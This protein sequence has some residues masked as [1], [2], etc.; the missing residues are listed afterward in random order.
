V[1]FDCAHDVPFDHAHDRPLVPVKLLRQH[2][3]I[4]LILTG[5]LVLGTVYSVVTPLFE[6]SDELWHYPFVKHLAEGGGLPVQDPRVEQ[7]WRQEGSQPPLYYAL[8]ALATFWI[9]T[10]DF[11]EVRWLNPH[12]DIGVETADGNLNMIVHSQREHFPYRG[13]AL[14]VHIV[15]FL[16][17]LMGAVT[18]LCTYLMALE[19]FPG[20]K[21]LAAGAAAFN[22][23]VPMFLFISGSV[24]NDNLTIL[25]C[26][27]TLLLLVRLLRG[28]TP[29]G[30][31]VNDPLRFGIWDLRLGH[32]SLLG[33]VIGLGALSKASAVGLLP[34]TALTLV[35]SAWQ[36]RAEPVL[37]RLARFLGSFATVLAVSLAVAGWWYLRNWLLYRDPLGLNTFVA[38][39]GPRLHQP[40]LRQLLGEWEGFVKAFW[41]LFGGVNVTMEPAVYWM[42]NVFAI[43]GL[44]GL[45]IALG[46]ALITR[47]TFHASKY[48]SSLATYHSSLTAHYSLLILLTWPIILFLAL[49][50]WTTITKASQGR[51]MFPAIS[52]IAILLALGWSQWVPHRFEKWLLGIVGGLMFASAAIAP[53]RYIVPAY[54]KPVLLSEAEL[55]AIPHR[56]DATF[57]SKAKLLGYKS[58]DEEI[59]PGESVEV[60]LY[61]Q[62]LAEMDRD[63][64]VF[65]H[66]LDENDLV[67]GQRDT[68]PGLGTY[69]TRLWRVGDAFAD[70]YVLTL[71]PTVFTPCTGRFEVG[72]YD[73]SS[74]ERLPVTGP[75]GQLLGDNIRF[76]QIAV[77]PRKD[78]PVPNP[79]DFDFEG[80]IALVG[81]DLDRR[82]ARSGETLRLTLYWQALTEMEEDYTV[83][84]HVLGEE[85]HLWAQMDSQPQG[86]TAPTSSWQ[87]G[88]VVEDHYDLVVKPDT[89]PD[90]YDIEVGLYQTATGQRLGVLDEGGRLRDN[91]VLLSKV[92]VK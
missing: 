72:L 33:L 67:I 13:T 45:M 23:F 19:I 65:V 25:L 84:T 35:L 14:A 79:V 18:V 74:E 56:L 90:V 8:G 48:D 44:A 50:R 34:L 59:R 81:Y 55:G 40:T 38:I 64:T 61:W 53:F 9:D 16:S 36:R 82:T 49:I 47:F 92:R 87:V 69:P 86:G 31:M 1:P 21:T 22:A 6:A 28:S 77:L 88:Q 52:A 91:R 58:D 63:Y 85:D 29:S 57:G 68:Y 4:I 80:R 12:A 2:G 20:Q 30:Q 89:P 15:R 75:D 3:A 43:L 71:P 7:P 41:G 70:R 54:A 60:T 83:F 73:F 42:L 10:S 26:S 62:S 46:R 5:F 11:A 78:S 51:L 76:H 32:C 27:L 24:N 37:H 17:V 66:L 39:V